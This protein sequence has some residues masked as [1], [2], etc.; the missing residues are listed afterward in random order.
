MNLILNLKKRLLLLLCIFL[1]AFFIISVISGVVMWKFGNSTPALR[2]ITVLQDLILFILPALVTALLVTR[3]PATLL[4][5]DRRPDISSLLIA[6][7]ALLL[8]VPAM[9]FIIWLNL[10]IPLPAE[11]AEALKSM[12]DNAADAVKALIGPHNIPNLIVSILI[13]GVLAGV[14]E[15]ILF[16]GGLQRLLV[17]GGVNHH[18]AIWITAVIFSMIHMQFYGFVPRM[19]LGAFFGYSLF[20]T[21]SL[22]VPIILHALNNTIYI[23]TEY[24]DYGNDEV[25][26]MESFGQGKDY[27]TVVCSVIGTVI[28]L[29]RLYL[30][31]KRHNFDSYV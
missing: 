20:W 8:S 14:S 12:E 6:I 26:V 18:A 3:Q 24:V 11:I 25:S 9:N 4:C 23:I 16:R 13:V 21:R 27:V 22:W 7:W 5:L 30:Y 10:N 31:C 1:V 15:E 19:L 2:I 29:R 17:T 28:L